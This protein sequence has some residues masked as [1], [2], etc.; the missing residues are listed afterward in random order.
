M[1]VF[2]HIPKTAGMA[3]KHVLKSNFGTR[4]VS[5][6]TWGKARAMTTAR[7]LKHELLAYPRAEVI[8]GH[9]MRPFVDYGERGRSF[10]WFTI[11]RDPRARLISHYVY[12]L[13][14]GRAG[15]SFEAWL[16][17]DVANYQVRW[18]AGEPDLEAARQLLDERFEVVGFQEDFR[19]SLVLLNQI[20]FE[21]RLTLT[22]ER[23]VNVTRSRETKD[24]IAAE[25][26]AHA[27]LVEA[28]TALDQA[29][30]DFARTRFW[31]PA[32]ERMGAANLED[33][34]ERA[35]G[36]PA[37]AGGGVRRFLYELHRNGV[38]KPVLWCAKA[39]GAR[40]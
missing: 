30:Y 25:L 16:R 11:L 2:C 4:F 3:V 13:E 24:R 9:G 21:D 32:V 26:E 6:T 15:D 12:D 33:R 8:G 1:I 28:A 17:S 18:I 40:E 20:M 39:L 29:L 38:Y 34:V 22:S 5:S 36:A 7:D 37:K 10:R 31:G 14:N 27:D 23:P 19:A 35:F